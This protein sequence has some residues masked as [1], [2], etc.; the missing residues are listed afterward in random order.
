[1]NL[2]HS[3]THNIVNKHKNNYSDTD[4]VVYKIR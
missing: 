4:T 2:K 3:I 1:M